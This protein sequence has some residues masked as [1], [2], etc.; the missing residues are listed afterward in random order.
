MLKFSAGRYIR[1]MVKRRVPVTSQHLWSPRLISTLAIMVDQNSS[2]TRESG[3][4]LHEM[5][6]VT[7]CLS[8]GWTVCASMHC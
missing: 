5:S 3:T 1:L 7:S 4:C 6:S 8:V 2:S